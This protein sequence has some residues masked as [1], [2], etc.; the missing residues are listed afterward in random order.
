MFQGEPTTEQAPTPTVIPEPTQ[1]P[2]FT[3]GDNSGSGIDEMTNSTDTSNDGDSIAQWEVAMIATFAV[4]LFVLASLICI[5]AAGI[6]IYRRWKVERMKR[7]LLEVHP[8]NLA[9]GNT[10]LN[11]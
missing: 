11:T 2:S 10:E 6:V 3:E 7:D 1:L 4:L 8:T 5:L 9:I